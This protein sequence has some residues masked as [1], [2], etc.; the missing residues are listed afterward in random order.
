MLDKVCH[1]SL[2]RHGSFPYPNRSSAGFPGPGSGPIGPCSRFIPAPAGNSVA[3]LGVGLG[4]SVH[5]RACGEQDGDRT[6]R[7][8][9]IGSSPRLRGTGRLLRFA[10]P[11]LRFIPAPAGNRRLPRC[12]T[13]PGSVHPRACGEQLLSQSEGAS[14]LGSSPRLRGTERPWPNRKPQQRFIPA[15]AGNS[16]G[17]RASATLAPVH[18]RACGEQPAPT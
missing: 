3:I 10:S 14:G 13:P 1:H 15:P 16:S 7:M 9:L 17:R 4:Q 6:A 8:G 11:S 5:P 18:P 12:R 2:I